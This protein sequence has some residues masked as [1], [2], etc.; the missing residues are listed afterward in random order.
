MD[1]RTILGFEIAGKSMP[2]AMR[3]VTSKDV[4]HRRGRNLQTEAAPV[5]DTTDLRPREGGRGG[6]DPSPEGKEGC[7]EGGGG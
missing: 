6:V 2:K 3:K 5:L 1:F 7:L 4:G